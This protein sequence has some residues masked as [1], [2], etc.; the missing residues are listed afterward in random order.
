MFVLPMVHLML[1]AYFSL[2][3]YSV[4]NKSLELEFFFHKLEVAMGD[5]LRDKRSQ[6]PDDK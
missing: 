6:L 2:K 3:E 5:K 4:G 1:R